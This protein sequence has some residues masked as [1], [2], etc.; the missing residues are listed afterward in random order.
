MQNII[1]NIVRILGLVLLQLM[2]FNGIHLFG[3]STPAVYLLALLL[4]P[5]ELPRSLQYLIGFAT[6]L[7]IDIFMHIQ[8]V[9]TA[10]CLIVM[11]V[12]PYLVKIL[13]GRN[14]TEGVDRPIPGVKDFKW[15]LM[16]VL[17]LSLLHQL[18]VVMLET[19]SFHNFGYTSLAILCNTIFTAFLVLCIEY[20]FFPI[21]KNQ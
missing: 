18:L 7:V 2:V 10:A 9:N 16:Y 5:L 15:L 19:K 3:F 13:N 20:I 4:L 8:G 11:F 6:G 12:R 1:I 21:R 14:S 17:L